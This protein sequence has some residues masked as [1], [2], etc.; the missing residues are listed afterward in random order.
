[1]GFFRSPSMSTVIFPRSWARTYPRFTAVV[2][3]P[4]P[5]T[6]LVTTTT[7]FLRS[8]IINVSLVAA[9]LNCSATTDAAF[10]LTT[11]LS[12]GRRQSGDPFLAKKLRFP[13]LFCRQAVNNALHLRSAP[14]SPSPP[15]WGNGV[16]GSGLAWAV[17]SDL[18]EPSV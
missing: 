2:D 8:A 15:P 10:H 11:K 4:S 14:P 17:G 12:S 5:C 13:F 9:T 6:A 18:A 16:R 1:M 7:V 3:L